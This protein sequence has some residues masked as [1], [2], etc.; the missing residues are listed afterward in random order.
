MNDILIVFAFFDTQVTPELKVTMVAGLEREGSALLC[1][2]SPFEET[3]LLKQ[4][5]PDFVSSNTR[6]FFMA[7]SRI[8]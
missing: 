2:R 4:E 6:N 7:L 1:K 5:L 3:A 8:S